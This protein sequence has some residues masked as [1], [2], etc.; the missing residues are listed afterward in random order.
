M[1]IIIGLIAR[2]TD[3]IIIAPR[4]TGELAGERR[5]ETA[6]IIDNHARG[7]II[8]ALLLL[9]LLIHTHKGI[10][11]VPKAGKG[12]VEV[13]MGR[14]RGW[15]CLITAILTND[16]HMQTIGARI[17]TIDTV[18]TTDAAHFQTIDT[19]VMIDAPLQTIDAGNITTRELFFC[20]ALWR[21][22]IV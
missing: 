3:G 12:I 1:A 14:A 2:W 11:I 9:I 15:I 21:R 16:A 17:Q 20:S 22:G 13:G 4:A 5:V 18:R 19:V 8:A 10:Q 6:I 7:A